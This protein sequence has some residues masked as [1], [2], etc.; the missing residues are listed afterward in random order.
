MRKNPPLVLNGPIYDAAV[1]PR[2]VLPWSLNHGQ[3]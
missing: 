3:A 2:G 1:F